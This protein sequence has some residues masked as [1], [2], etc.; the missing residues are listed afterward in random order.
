MKLNVL[1]HRA[2]WAMVRNPKVACSGRQDVNRVWIK[3]SQLVDDACARSL[4][5][6]YIRITLVTCY[7]DYLLWITSSCDTSHRLLC[8]RYICVFIG[9]RRHDLILNVAL[10]CNDTFLLQLMVN[11]RIHLRL[12][13][14]TVASC[15]L[16][17]CSTTACRF[18]TIVTAGLWL[19]SWSWLIRNG[20]K[21]SIKDCQAWLCLLCTWCLSI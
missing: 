6:R 12:L 8:I 17:W 2:H 21:L 5:R 14:I 15:S 4:T 7:L 11:E 20:N 1:V 13:S 10:I 19:L 16:L 18:N 3:S 9:P